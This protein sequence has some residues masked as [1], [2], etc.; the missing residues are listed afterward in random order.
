[1]MIYTSDMPGLAKVLESVGAESVFTVDGQA[2]TAPF[3]ARPWGARGQ[4][5]SVQI[6]VPNSALVTI[7]S[8]DGVAYIQQKNSYAPATI[9]DEVTA[10]DTAA[11]DS[12]R[13]RIRSSGWEPPGVTKTNGNTV[14]PTSWAVAREHNAYDVWRTYGYEG[15]GVNVAVVDTGEDFGH[16][17]LSG[18]WAVDENPASPY[19]GWPI[20]FHPASM[21]GLM[22]QGWWTA[23]SDFD[24]LPLPFWLSANDGDSWY[25][26]TDFR[27][28]DTDLDGSLTYAQGSP[29]PLNGLPQYTPRAN[30]QQYGNYHPNWNSR[31]NRD[32]YVGCAGLPGPCILSQS[33]VYRLGV[34]RD[35]TLT[36]LWGEKV[37]ILVVDST[38]PFVYDTV[39]VDLNF[40]FDFTDDKPVTRADP[41]VP[42]AAPKPVMLRII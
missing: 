24:R 13:D 36:G 11:F 19:F 4:M 6:Q 17:S 33:G 29:D 38:T 5:T 16:P 23:G 14:S 15:G 41:T 2:R 21:E 34:D 27:A 35:D 42:S 20:M 1:V 7:A 39:Y 25:S 12:V 10:E 40:N 30:P 28:N 3:T 22:G 8:L 18:A 37:G 32:Y 9:Q 26:N 31:I